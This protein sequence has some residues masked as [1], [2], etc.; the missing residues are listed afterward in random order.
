[1]ATVVAR[2]AHGPV[3][4]ARRSAAIFLSM[5]G[6]DRS[7]ALAA[8]MFTALIP[9]LIVVAAIFESGDGGSLGDA[10]VSRLGLSGATADSVRRVLPASSSV[11]SAIS[12]LSVGILVISALSFT[13]ALQRLYE[14]AWGLE[15]RGMRD[16][17]YG[18]LWLAGFAALVVVHLVLHGHING[19]QG[20]ISSI[21]GTFLIWLVT[22]YV[23]VARRLPWRVLVPQALITAVSLTIFRAGSAIYM[24]TAI[25]SSAEQFGALGVCFA[26]I[27]WMFGAATVL[28]G[29]AAVGA[30]VSSSRRARTGV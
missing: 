17:A 21:A 16:T 24:P 20:L 13:R 26:L 28:A 3:D 29:S 9:M 10:V 5:A 12:A 27:S 30:A 11:E 4:L 8:Q 19:E 1:M 22:P 18:L 7:M 15:P 23:I 25:S 14:R 2:F 6:F